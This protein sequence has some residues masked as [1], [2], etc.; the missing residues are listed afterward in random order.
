MDALGPTELVIML[1]V[2]VLLL[3]VGRIGKLISNLGK[4]Q[5]S[6]KK[7]ELSKPAPQST[8][9]QAKAPDKTKSTLSEA[10]NQSI[11]KPP[12]RQGKSIFLSYRREDS[13]DVT[14]R[15]YD[16]LVQHYGVDNIF[17]DVDSIPLG[18]DFRDH[19]EKVVSECDV[20]VAIIGKKWLDMKNSSGN[21]RINDPRDFVRIE[22]ES[23]LKR[24]IPVIPVLVQ[25]AIMP[26]ET[27]LPSGLKELSYRNGIQVRPD[28][29]FHN[30]MDRLIKGLG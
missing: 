16:R 18:V 5:D 23:A 12:K 28:P 11:T 30:D 14:G 2:V 24:R 29:D 3:G 21:R 8:H 1:V 9:V 7:K 13:A 20:L 26:L 22:I 6:S 10:I 25:N 19:L 4:R 15:I 17:K 27:D